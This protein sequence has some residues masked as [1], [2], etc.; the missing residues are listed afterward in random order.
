MARRSIIEEARP[1][2]ARPGYAKPIDYGRSEQAEATLDRYAAYDAAVAVETEAGHQADAA[3][4]EL[5]AAE[6]Q[7]LGDGRAA[8]SR[9]IDEARARAADADKARATLMR[10]RKAVADA[11]GRLAEAEADVEAAKAKH[12]AT[13]L[14]AAEGDTIAEAPVAMRTA[15]HRA[16]D[17]AD[18]LD[19]AR[20][21]LV[22]AESAVA[23]TEYAERHSAERL[24]GAARTVLAEAAAPLTE[25][26]DEIVAAFKGP[27]LC[28]LN[29][30]LSALPSFFSSAFSPEQQRRVRVDSLLRDVAAL[31]KPMLPREAG[32]PLGG[33]LFETTLADLKADATA[34]LPELP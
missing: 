4:A 27:M 7:E 29:F 13:L 28:R 11:E 5:E 17:A 26:L 14:D 19:A 32:F 25:G 1:Q 2:A 22:T 12:A 24:D 20:A 15:R 8:L 16:V 9:A 34:V 33:E 18:D 3:N 30:I 10:V 23:D 6:R 31:G 21:V